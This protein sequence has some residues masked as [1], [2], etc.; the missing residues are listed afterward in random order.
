MT[1]YSIPG[2]SMKLYALNCIGKYTP[3]GNMEPCP[4]EM[5][6]LTKEFG[7]PRMDIGI[8]PR[9]QISETY[10][11]WNDIEYNFSSTQC[12]ECHEVS[13]RYIAQIQQK[14]QRQQQLPWNRFKRLVKRS[15]AYA[16]RYRKT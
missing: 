9:Q 3:D 10:G 5:Y 1:F 7:N 11:K 15:I 2:K 14:F 6:K 12:P 4:H 13:M 8:F 16:R